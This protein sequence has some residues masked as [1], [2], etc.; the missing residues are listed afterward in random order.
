[1]GRD[2]RVAA[3]T[4]AGSR[5]FVLQQGKSYLC[6]H[7]TYQAYQ[8]SD[9]RKH[10]RVHTGEK[11]FACQFCPVRFADSSNLRRHIRTHGG[12]NIYSSV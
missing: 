1:M 4:S 8:K 6:S 5:S 11:P 12:D 10:I 3:E 9:L 2:V 7:C